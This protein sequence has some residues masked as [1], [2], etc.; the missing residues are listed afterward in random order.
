MSAA[1][2]SRVEIDFDH[3]G[4][5]FRDD[6]KGAIR[7][8]HATGCPMGHSSQYGGFWAF[9]GYDAVRDA[10]R[11]S[12]LF[13]SAHTAETPKG[14]PSVPYAMPLLPID[15]DGEMVTHYRRIVLN[16]LSPA[17]AKHDIPRLTEIC[18]ELID[19]FIESGS[20]DI[21]D[22]LLTPLP[23]RWILEKLNWSPDRWP[24][25]IQWVHGLSHDAAHDPERGA[26]AAEQLVANVN[27]EIAS[28]RSDLGDDVLSDIIR[29]TD[30]DEQVRGFSL[31]LL[32]GGMDTTAGLTSNVL[33]L[34]DREPA[35]R[36]RLIEEPGGIP[37]YAEEFLRLEAPAPSYRTVTDD[38]EFHGQQ[39][40]KGDRVLL[41][42]GAAGLDPAIFENPEDIDLD[43]V[44]NRHLSFGVGPHRCL[45]SH[46]AR[47]MFS[48]MLAEIIRRMPDFRISGEVERFESAGNVYAIRRLPISFTPGKRSTES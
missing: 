2:P 11:D 47:V 15:V 24:E 22:A 42:F 4:A 26:W 13:S 19:D 46:H 44:G 12:E 28:R 21:V 16:T 39:L 8:M 9:Y 30:T 5:E 20:C 40:R 3:H 6:N 10:A 36:Q 43:R 34:I 1:D 31:L 37:K 23:A 38:A 48:V 18:T 32:L 33:E 25:W 17:G 7:R 45:G 27:A 41:M 29:A 35:V 14:V